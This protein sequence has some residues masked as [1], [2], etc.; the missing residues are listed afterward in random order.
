M[1]S[2]L[3]HARRLTQHA[4]SVIPIKNKRPVLEKWI[5]RRNQ[6]A[7]DEEL[8]MWFSN[9]K[10]EGVT[11]T[12]DETQFAIDTDGTGESLLQDRIVHRFSSVLKDKVHRT[13]HT[14]TPHGHHRSFRVKHED[15]PEG[16]REK[17]IVKLDGHNEIA[18]KGKNHYLVERGEGY[19]I[20][21]DVDCIV[22]LSKEE[23]I[24]L[25]K[26]LDNFKSESNGIKTVLS[27][28]IPHYKQLHVT[29]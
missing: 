11:I 18:V 7:T 14:K 27:V 24:E 12:I 16:I 2:L 25:F 23:T 28:L 10:A 26:M 8:V 5:D 19:D 3:E 29:K 20:V 4:F 6:L 15:F 21:N 22:T 13:M 9:G 1:V 17:S